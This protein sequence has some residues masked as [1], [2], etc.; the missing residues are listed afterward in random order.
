MREGVEIGIKT[1]PTPRGSAA[2]CT[3]SSPVTHQPG[4]A[5]ASTWRPY[6]VTV[7]RLGQAVRP[8]NSAML[9]SNI[10]A[11][12]CNG[13]AV[14]HGSRVIRARKADAS[15][16]M[17]LPPPCAP[18][19]QAAEVDGLKQQLEQE[20]TFADGWDR[21]TIRA[22]CLD[23][24]LEQLNVDVTNIA[25]H[26]GILEDTVFNPEQS[27]EFAVT[28]LLSGRATMLPASYSGS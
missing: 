19:R 7:V 10:V 20:Q 25:T 18:V 24:E 16:I 1:V 12:A 9:S 21:H 3:E 13:R 28:V 22:R 5:I 15:G 4:K 2:L 23:D 6:S 17:P 27:I 8:Q 26:G 11:K 14:P